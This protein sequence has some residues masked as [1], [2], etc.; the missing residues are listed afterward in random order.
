M[1]ALLNFESNT[2]MPVRRFQSI[3][4]S[5]LLIA[6]LFA[7]FAMTIGCKP[8]DSEL[9]KQDEQTVVEKPAPVSLLLVGAEKLGPEI[10]R[11]WLARRDGQL[12]CVNMSVA[13]FLADVPA[14]I[15]EQDAIVYPPAMIGQ[16][17]AD[18]RILEVPK[19]TWKDNEFNRKLLRN[20]RTISITYGRKRWALPLGSPHLCLMYRADVIQALKAKPPT[21][22]SEFFALAET[23]RNLEELTDS[24]GQALPL[25]V[26]MPASPGWAANSLLAVAAARSRS[27][28]KLTTVFDMKDASPLINTPPFV[29]ALNEIKGVFSSH[30]QQRSPK[31]IAVRMFSG[32][33]AMAVGWPSATFFDETTGDP[34]ENVQIIS[35]PGSKRWYDSE[36]QKWQQR[37]EPLAVDLLGVSGLNISVLRTTDDPNNTFDFAAWLADK[38][39]ALTTVSRSAASG[40]F[41]NSHLGDVFRWSGEQLS[42]DTG[43]AFADLIAESQDRKVYF[44]FPRIPGNFEYMSALD[45]AV[46]ECLKQ[47]SSARNCLNGVAEKWSEITDRL[48]AAQQKGALRM[49]TGI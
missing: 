11:Q 23:L 8:S 10:K 4:S 3:P 45:S 12:S 1:T 38:Q 43:N 28:G 29:D 35:L 15:A 46:K 22:W 32:E 9:S 39:I 41:H 2:V 47:Q 40:P 33:T 13:E 34:N 14:A 30:P 37:N 25:E 42:Q 5:V 20:S 31:E 36:Q 19:N 17:V 6:L 27:Q 16:L 44:L 21:T 18:D 48:G 26:D 7:M 49:N 24:E